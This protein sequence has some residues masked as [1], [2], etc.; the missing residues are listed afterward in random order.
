MPPTQHAIDCPNPHCSAP[1]ALG[2]CTRFARGF[3][4]EI[5]A[6]GPHSA[7]WDDVHC[8]VCGHFSTPYAS[9]RQDGRDLRADDAWLAAV[10]R[11]L[12][13]AKRGRLA[14]YLEA[15]QLGIVDLFAM[16]RAVQRLRTFAAL[17]PQERAFPHIGLLRVAAGA[18]LPEMFGVAHGEA[19]SEPFERKVHVLGRLLGADTAETSPRL[20]A[21]SEP[22][23]TWYF[24][25]SAA[26]IGMLALAPNRS[27]RGTLTID[28]C[29]TRLLQAG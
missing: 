3:G 27:Y 25:R 10:D 8:L 15:N 26:L 19:E 17:A 6:S 12:R 11:A 2:L 13:L 5:D 20:C 7:R 22:R 14:P 9:A 28:G 4:L 24:Y 16:R 1:A 21:S 18:Q 29:L 23:R